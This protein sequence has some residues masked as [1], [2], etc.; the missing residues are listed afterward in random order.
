MKSLIKHFLVSLIII[1][2]SGCTKDYSHYQS[3]EDI[4]SEEYYS[5]DI[6]PDSLQKLYGSWKL[7]A[8]T[9]GFS[10]SGNGKEFDYLVFK[11]NGIFGVIKDETLIAYGKLTLTY[12][13]HSTLLNFIPVK[14]SE[15]DLC[16]DPI[17]NIYFVSNDTLNLNAPCCDRFNIHLVRRN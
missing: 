15:I 2:P 6:M 4:S 12:K 13:T 8:S 7:I 1:I 17:K 14:S 3:I 9:G 11:R 16:T 10:G 5:S